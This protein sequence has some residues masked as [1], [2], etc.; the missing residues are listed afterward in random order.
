MN[1]DDIIQN[2]LDD[3]SIV[4]VEHDKYTL[5][6]TATKSNNNYR[7]HKEN[8]KATTK[9][10]S[11]TNSV[12]ILTMH[13]RT[14][15]ALQYLCVLG[16]LL[17]TFYVAMSFPLTNPMGFFSSDA[18][19]YSVLAFIGIFIVWQFLNSKLRVKP[20]ITT[21][22]R[23]PRPRVPT[24]GW[25]GLISS[26]FSVVFVILI[27]VQLYVAGTDASRVVNVHW[28]HFN[29]FNVEV[30][31]FFALGAI[32]IVNCFIVARSWRSKHV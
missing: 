18:F 20:I 14:A 9:T 16:V 7:P 8:A 27:W 1:I 22:P 17:T 29:E 24:A 32:I 13:L 31:L 23:R 6:P 30:V 26:I 10:P 28:N 5:A 3:G 15:R 25:I 12:Y 11:K 4:E 21:T 19:L 2:L